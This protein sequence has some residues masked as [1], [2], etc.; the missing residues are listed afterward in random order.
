MELVHYRYPE[1]VTR[2]IAIKD[3]GEGHL[4]F[5]V[6]DADAEYERLAALGGSE[7]GAR[8]VTRRRMLRSLPPARLRYSP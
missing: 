3:P 6:S 7:R 2:P 5:A 8:P 1:G 4:A